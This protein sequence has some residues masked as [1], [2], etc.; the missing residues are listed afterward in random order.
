MVVVDNLTWFLDLES[1]LKN[2]TI[3]QN[4]DFRP[5]DRMDTW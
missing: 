3:K 4:A 1:L 5:T 2:F